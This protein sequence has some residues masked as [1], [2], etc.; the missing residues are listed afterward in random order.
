[1]IG[2]HAPGHR[3]SRNRPEGVLSEGLWFSRVC[4]GELRHRAHPDDDVR[5]RRSPQLLSRY[6]LFYGKPECVDECK[7]PFVVLR[8]EIARYPGNCD[9][10]VFQFAAR[11]RGRRRQ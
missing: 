10:G 2:F 6:F 11:R 9:G 1:M 7:K 5:K 4:F 8:D 3:L